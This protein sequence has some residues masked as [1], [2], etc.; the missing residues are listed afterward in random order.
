MHFRLQLPHPIVGGTPALLQRRQPAERGRTGRRAHPHPVLRNPLQLRNPRLEQG[1]K[2]V[3]Q[4]PLQQVAVADPEV[5]Q[6]LVVDADAA[7]QPLEGD[8]LGAK[9]RQRAGAA[10]AFDRGVQPQ[11]Q[12]HPRIG[13]RV[14]GTSLHRFDPIVKARQ[15]ELLAER[16]HQAHPMIGRHQVVQAQRP[17]LHLPALGLTQARPAADRLQRRRLLGQFFEQTTSA[18][19]RHDASGEQ[20][21]MPILPNDYRSDSPKN[22]IIGPVGRKIHRL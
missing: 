1:R 3:D 18:F 17:H 14:S 15:I 8:M 6:R 16:P 2:A 13:R 19:A 4:Q 5:A 11:R 20:I 9:T 22:L 21:T 7:T 12:Q 10:D